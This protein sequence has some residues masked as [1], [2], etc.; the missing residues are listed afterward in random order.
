MEK[1]IYRDSKKQDAILEHIK[2]NPWVEQSKLIKTFKGQFKYKNLQSARKCVGE[3][4]K[5]L[6]AN[7]RVEKKRIRNESAG[8]IPKN[9][10][11]AM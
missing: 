1:K 11:R 5:K 7:G 3:M 9:L 2:K 8:S 4:L 6:E 10:W